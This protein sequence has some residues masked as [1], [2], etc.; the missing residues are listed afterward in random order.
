MK[1][2]KCK[3]KMEE[4][5]VKVEGATK[6]IKSY[7][8]ECGYFKF[9]QKTGKAVV[10]EIESKS[11]SP[12]NIKQKVIKISHGR[13]GSYWDENVIRATGLKAG[14]ILFVSVPDKKH[15]LISLE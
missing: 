2:P 3:E 15:I 8:C 11:K 14:K 12:L 13:L 4:S 1:C 9:D 7:Q 10:K 6:K 5:M